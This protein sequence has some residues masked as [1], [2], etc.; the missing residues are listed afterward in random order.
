VLPGFQDFHVHPAAI[1]DPERAVDLHGLTRR[2]EISRTH[3]QF[4]GSTSDAALD[5]GLTAGTRLP[6]CRAGSRT[7]ETSMPWCPAVRP[8]STNNSGHEGLANS[9]ALA[10]AGI[11]RDTPDPVNGRI[12]HDADGEPSGALQESAAM[13]QVERVIPSP[14]A[15]DYRRTLTAALHTMNAHGITALEDAMATPEIAAA[16]R[17]LD[18]AGRLPMRV[19]LRLRASRRRPGRAADPPIYGCNG[20]AL[21]GRRMK[22]DCVK[23]FLD[24]AYGSHTVALLEPYADGPQY[25]RGEIF[26]AQQR[27]NRLITRLD[28]LGFRRISMRRATRPS[29]RRLMR[30]QPRVMPTATKGQC[31]QSHTSTS[32]G[33]QTSLASGRS[34]SRANMAPLWSRQDPVGAGASR[35]ACSAR[36]AFGGLFPTR[37]LLKNDALLVWGSDWPVTDVSPIEGLETAVTRRYAGGRD[38]EG[39]EDLAP[40]CSRS[41][42]RRPKRS[43]HTPSTVPGCRD[44]AAERGTLTSGK[45]ADFVV[46]DRDPDALPALSIHASARG[47]LPSSAATSYMRPPPALTVR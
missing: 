9:R 46:R 23:V 26:I 21:S 16:Y 30:S 11:D 6:S 43:P 47:N 36:G 8:I 3:P 13:E 12:E 39:Q 38:P 35:R 4:R 42:R 41:P 1:P 40:Q 32:L 31:T 25:G 17:T 2:D 5:F 24:G 29:A 27:L 33:H 28:R 18:I 44:E 34:G 14:T 10:A 37:Q 20:A 15:E 45:L 7:G 22:A 19:H